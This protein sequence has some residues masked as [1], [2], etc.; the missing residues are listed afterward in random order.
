MIEPS[1][2]VRGD[3]TESRIESAMTKRPLFR[4]LKCPHPPKE[5][6]G[7]KNVFLNVTAERQALAREVEG[8][9]TDLLPALEESVP[10]EVSVTFRSRGSAR[11][12]ARHLR[13]L[14]LQRHGQE[15]PKSDSTHQRL[16]HSDGCSIRFSVQEFLAM[17]ADFQSVLSDV[18]SLPAG[19]NCVLNRRVV[20]LARTYHKMFRQGYI[21][22]INPLAEGF[23]PGMVSLNE[24]SYCQ[25]MKEAHAKMYDFL[26]DVVDSAVEKKPVEDLEPSQVHQVEIDRDGEILIDGKAPRKLTSAAKAGI[27][28]LALLDTETVEL[29]QFSRVYD[30]S[31]LHNNYLGWNLGKKFA[32]AIDAMKRVLPHIEFAVIP[33]QRRT[34]VG[35]HINCLASQQKLR[36]FL[37]RRR[38][39]IIKTDADV[40]RRMREFGNEMAKSPALR[41]QALRRLLRLPRKVPSPPRE[42]AVEADSDEKFLKERFGASSSLDAKETVDP[43]PEE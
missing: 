9:W 34:V 18:A 38:E 22:K 2:G 3:P 7:E 12:A 43:D 20:R 33:K 6:E 5:M 1:D 37:T 13:D 16:I 25:K 21:S 14:G 32:Q 41:N 8:L 39:H 17:E 30:P 26:S 40:E 28:A 27:Y 36:A 35:L 29:K 31:V 24:E 4:I 15:R 23:P 11:E 19:R 10:G 42:P